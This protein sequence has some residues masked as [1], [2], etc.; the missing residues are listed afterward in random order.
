MNVS[1]PTVETNPHAPAAPGTQA[2]SPRPDL[3]HARAGDRALTGRL[4]AE[5]RDATKRAIVLGAAAGIVGGEAL[6]LAETPWWVSA[7]F[8]V[9][10]VFVAAV[11]L[12]LILIGRADRHLH[13][14]V[15]RAQQ[16]AHRHDLTNFPDNPP[17]HGVEAVT[18]W[19]AARPPDPSDPSILATVG[20]LLLDLGRYDEARAVI[21]RIDSSRPYD[22]FERAIVLAE[23]DFEEGRSGDLGRA[24]ELADLVPGQDG[25]DALAELALSEAK[26]LVIDGRPW[27]PP[28]DAAYKR[29]GRPSLGTIVKVGLYVRANY[30]A[31]WIVP[32]MLFGGMAVLALRALF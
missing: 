7:T 8:A 28:I 17:P 13:F 6:T 18:R 15:V 9:I 1:T 22:Q 2:V 25:P 4:R 23:I 20:S 24:R 14:I 27:A 26:R 16:A 30:Y 32:A 19:L 31:P 3:R 11:W 12:P 10:A 5:F 29:I 21:E